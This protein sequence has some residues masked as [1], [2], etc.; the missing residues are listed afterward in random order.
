MKSTEGALPG[1]GSDGDWG[2]DGH[3]A[4]ETLPAAKSTFG[5]RA[6]VLAGVLTGTVGMSG[7]MTTLQ[8]S[9]TSMSGPLSH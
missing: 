1:C 6:L 3:P 7:I 4:G 8:P 2:T 9:G 5:R